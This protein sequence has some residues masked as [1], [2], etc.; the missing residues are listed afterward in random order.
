MQ[1]LKDVVGDRRS[2]SF[3]TID[4]NAALKRQQLKEES[5]SIFDIVWFISYYRHR[6]CF[7]QI[8]DSKEWF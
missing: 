3:N 7:R 5:Y 4:D 1:S 6:K 8:V 2:T